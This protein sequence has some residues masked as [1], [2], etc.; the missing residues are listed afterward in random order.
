MDVAGDVNGVRRCAEAHDFGVE[1]DGDVDFVFAGQEEQRKTGGA[2]FAVL[3]D[4][5]DLVDLLLD[6]GRGHGRREE[7]DVRAEVGRLRRRAKC[8][9]GKKQ[10]CKKEGGTMA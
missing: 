10:E 1:T 3:L 7:K 9:G 8:R 2:E 5:V 6:C 4:G